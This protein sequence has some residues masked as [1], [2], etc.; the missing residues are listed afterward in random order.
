MKA[1]TLLEDVGPVA[2]CRQDLDFLPVDAQAELD[3]VQALGAQCCRTEH[4]W[5]SLV[6][7][8]EPATMNR[9]NLSGVFPHLRNS[10]PR[11][12]KTP[13][14]QPGGE[15]GTWKEKLTSAHFFSF[16]RLINFSATLN[17]WTHPGVYIHHRDSNP[18]LIQEER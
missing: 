8:S 18:I 2:G 15:N 11:R 17:I 9:W 10:I 6:C 13:L 7:C 3:P 14:V 1:S 12:Y 16:F 5:D 4:E